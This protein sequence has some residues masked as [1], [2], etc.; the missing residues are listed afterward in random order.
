MA[1]GAH[2]VD[3]GTAISAQVRTNRHPG[4]CAHTAH[5][6]NWRARAVV[7]VLILGAAFIASAATPAHVSI[8]FE[9][10]IADARYPE[11]VYWFITP[12][13]FAP[14]R[15]AQDIHHIAN[16]TPFTFAF[17]TERN[18]V[19][20]L[21]NPQPNGYIPPSCPKWPP[22]C[23]PFPGNT[24]SH[25][26]TAEIVKDA[27]RKGLKIG[28][29]FDW[30]V[31][32]TTQ[33]IPLD[34][35]QTVISSA[36]ASLDAQGRATV[37]A[38][39]KMRF[40]GPEESHLLR[41]YAFRKT[42]AGEYDPATLEDVTAKAQ[43]VARV[44]DP[45]TG[46][47]DI[48]VDL[49]PKYAG[50]TIF[51]LQQ[52]WL[53]AMDLFSDA[54]LNWVHSALDE[55]KNVP[56]DGTALDEFGYTRLLGSPPWRGLFAGKAFQAHFDTST[57]LKLPETLFAMSYCPS[58][59]P[60]VRIKAIDVYWDFL[61]SGPLRIEKEFYRYSRKIYGD[62]V[63]AG[64]HSTIH[65]HL[66]NDEPWASGLDWW[67][68]PRQYGMSDEDLSLPLR[69]GLLLSHPGKIMYDQ[70]YDWNIQRFAEKA[71]NDARFDARIHYHGY[72]DTGA[73]GADISSQKFLDTINPVEEK[74]RLLNR[75]DPAAP[76]VPLLVVFGMPRLL[77]WYPDE[78]DRNNFNV[79]GSL[80]IEEKVKALWD[81]GY[82]CA[83]VPSDLIDNGA[84]HLD[85]RGHPVLNGHTF[86]A[87]IYLYPE[88]SKRSTLAFLDSYVRHGGAL[89][90]E[91]AATRDFDGKPIA[92]LFASIQDKARV[93][94]FNIDDIE[95]LGI[96]KDPL[97]AIGGSL[98]DGSVIL[99][100]LPS[101]QQKSPK[102][103]A[104]NVDGHEFSGTYEGV[105]AMKANSRGA[106]EK[107]AC[108]ECETLSRD[109]QQVLLLKTPADLIVLSDGKGGYNAVVSGASASNSI[110]ITR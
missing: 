19:L 35:D 84:L 82:R 88:Y 70:Y 31:V 21:K 105:F 41:V 79:N 8:S 38:G 2:G 47:M 9:Q 98:E 54:Y 83:V 22:W 66:T 106:I 63:F 18:G 107:L 45:T 62:K 44:G 39:S 48:A 24:G 72:N 108:G 76:Q 110:Q 81:A 52:T 109:G 85:A 32:D 91:G 103:F 40:T 29:T 78:A 57:G 71:L 6:A 33:L 15:V 75:F 27:H 61:R 30:L 12:E 20:L 42:A 56:L 77:N 16:D 1:D 36:E 58:G 60:E 46:L 87:I 90:L 101:L 96:S 89:M 104:V 53:N 5:S 49:G 65:N 25:A 73:W 97:R 11:L 64:I 94:G 10:T 100:D 17:L 51:A 67:T 14:G 86:R 7:A 28:L 55:Y 102:A 95:K 80:H 37:T 68:E 13:T 50:E 93:N 69:M 3:G 74:I 43:G 59:H 4:K 99:T 92:G 23:T 34:E 26:L